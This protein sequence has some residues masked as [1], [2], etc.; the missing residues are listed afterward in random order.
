MNA[1][2][3]EVSFDIGGKSYR[4][5]ASFEALAN[6]EDRLGVGIARI[7][8]RLQEPTMRDIGIMLEC[9]SDGAINADVRR[10]NAADL[11]GAIDAIAQTFRSLGWGNDDSGNG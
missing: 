5:F 2:R 8:E 6:I 4:L 11:R 7:G 1:V 3:G 9:L 10:E